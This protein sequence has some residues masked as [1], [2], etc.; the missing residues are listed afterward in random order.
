MSTTS[1]TWQ[2]HLGG[3]LIA[4]ILC[5]TF[6][7]PWTHGKLLNSPGFE[8]FRVYFS[9]DESWPETQEF[10]DLCAE[11]RRCGEFSISNT[12]TGERFSNVTLNQSGDHIWFRYF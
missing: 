11:I 1:T 10:D 7:F 12:E 8:R 4:T 3:T 5:D 6:E 9:D 2:L